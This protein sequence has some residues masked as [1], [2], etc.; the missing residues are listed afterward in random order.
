MRPRFTILIGR[1]K[2]VFMGLGGFIL[3]SA[4][5]SL[6]TFFAETLDAER[7]EEWIRKYLKKEVTNR[8]T[9]VLKND[10]SNPSD[11][12][13]AQRL[14]DDMDRIDQTVFISVKVNR[15]LFTPP[16]TTRRMFV[17]KAVL[18]SSEG[19]E[20]TR[21]F[22]LSAENR[23]FDFFWVNEYSRWMWFFSI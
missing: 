20:E 13:A 18:R 11:V 10:G 8:F 22:T 23:F 9:H 12:E 7:A 16:F 14:K 2:I 4:L 21:F 19:T 5:L 15:F 3:I 17:V 6:P 1:G